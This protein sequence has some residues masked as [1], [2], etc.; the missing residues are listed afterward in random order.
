MN[1]EPQGSRRDTAISSLYREAASEVP[2]ASLDA[3]VLRRAHAAVKD[4]PA[5]ASRW[6]WGGWQTRFAVLATVVM[7][8]TLLLVYQQAAQEGH[9]MQAIQKIT[10]P[11][12][13][14]TARQRAVDAAPGSLAAP[15]VAPPP[16]GKVA[17]DRVAAGTGARSEASPAGPAANANAG[18]QA[19]MPAPSVSAPMTAP[20]A[21][22]VPVPPQAFPP[23][24]APAPASEAPR[25]VQRSQEAEGRA[26]DVTPGPAPAAAASRPG[27]AASPPAAPAATVRPLDEWL[28]RIRELRRQGKQAEAVREL[29]ALRRQYPEF[30]LPED[31]LVP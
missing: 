29:E 27:A 6:S 13:A 11:G 4:N 17:P 20:P 5:R 25:A 28:S 8:F 16:A 12:T 7:S 10:E 1:D 23:P 31:L 3:A 30:K 9:G 18:F 21:A 24:A 19:G 15:G 26:R 14:G 2:P 22:P